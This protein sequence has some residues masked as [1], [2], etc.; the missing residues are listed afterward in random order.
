MASVPRS[1]YA[2]RE[3]AAGERAEKHSSHVLKLRTVYALA[4]AVWLVTRWLVLVHQGAWP[5]M[6]AFVVAAARGIVFGDWNEAVRP[7]LP[8]V[9]GVP[10]VL[11]GASEQ[12]AV[13]ALYVLAGLVQ[14][15]AFVVLVRALFPGRLAEQALALLVFL[16]VPFNHSIHHYRD[17]PVVLASSAVFLL[18]ATWL[19][20]WSGDRGPRTWLLISGAML[21]GV[22]SR[23]EVLTFVGVLVVLGIAVWRRRA[24]ALVATYVVAAGMVGGSLLLVYRLEGVDL[25]QASRYQW[26]TFLDSTP[27]S[28]LTP[29][30]RT[31]PTENCREADGLTY[32]GPANPEAGVVPML[33]N[34]PLA[35]LAKTLRSAADN[36]WD[37]LGP[38]L[39]TFPGSVPFV[40]LG[41]AFLR[42]AREA[43]LQVPA[44]GWMVM[45]AVVG[46]S[47]LPPLSWAPPHPQYHLQMVLPIAT[48]LV[49][50]LLGLARMPRGRL[51]ALAFLIGNAG[52]SAFRYTRYP[53]Y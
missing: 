36:L 16:L 32:F 2:A 51:V 44:A 40:L 9:L 15:G 10:L 34:H 49:P 7:Q 13:A 39:S 23:A 45:L 38:N 50:L 29:G 53:G 12:Q 47:V 35:A 28:W 11:A 27:D 42:P 37:L 48:L 43:L 20:W 5:W 17:V 21:L 24:L 46:E 25:S 19:T 4:L 3:R 31:A 8:A 26:H 6:N 41:Y 33:L 30:C 18:S 22:W 52:L 14:F 1:A